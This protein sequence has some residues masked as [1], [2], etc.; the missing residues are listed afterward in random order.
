M[1]AVADEIDWRVIN[2]MLEQWGRWVE[3]HAAEAGYPSMAAIAGVI[4]WRGQF[5]WFRVK[6]L[7]ANGHGDLIFGGH[8]ILCVDMPERVRQTNLM[9]NTLPSGQYDAVLAQY[10]LGVRED[11][12][13]F[14][15]IE[16]ARALGI[17]VVALDERLRRARSHLANRLA[18]ATG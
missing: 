17:T 7:T 2:C 10:G 1:A 9:V 13:R 6:Q 16:K 12:L 18:K 5:N 3:D 14:T 4:D 11:G 15:S 8:R